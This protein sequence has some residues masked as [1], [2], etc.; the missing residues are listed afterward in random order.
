MLEFVRDRPEH[1]AH[2]EEFELLLLKLIFSFAPVTRL[3]YYMVCQPDQTSSV[4]LYSLSL[5]TLAR[6]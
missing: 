1:F 6:R 3:V 4:V 5:A 2:H